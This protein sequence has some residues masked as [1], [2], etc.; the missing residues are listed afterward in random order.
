MVTPSP[1][2]P[3]SLQVEFDHDTTPVSGRI[4]D[5]A[6]AALAF[7]GWTELFAALRAA[8]DEQPP[9]HGVLDSRQNREDTR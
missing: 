6:G 9:A 3:L 7:V 4:K 8:V 2:Q 1:P 5:G